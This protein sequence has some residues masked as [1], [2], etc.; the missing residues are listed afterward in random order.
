[1]FQPDPDQQRRGGDAELQQRAGRGEEAHRQCR[2]VHPLRQPHGERRRRGR[3]EDRR[4]VDHGGGKRED[5]EDGKP[6]LPIDRRPR[7]EDKAGDAAVAERRRQ[8]ARAREVD[9]R[10]R[11]ERDQQQERDLLDDQAGDHRQP[12]RIVDDE[13]VGRPFPAGQF[14]R[15]ERAI[16]PDGAIRKARPNA[17]AA[18]GTDSSGEIRCCMRRTAACRQRRRR[19]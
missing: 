3:P 18:C 6:D 19:K 16:I 15:Q 13:Q 11:G 12:Q 10:Q 1:M 14:R 8:H 4:H 2:I 17:A 7:S 5:G 9:L